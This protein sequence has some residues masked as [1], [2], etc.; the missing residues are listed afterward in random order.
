M[1][2]SSKHTEREYINTVCKNKIKAKNSLLKVEKHSEIE[3]NIIK[4]VRN[5]FG[6]KTEITKNKCQ[7]S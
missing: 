4:D 6:L 7:Y 2:H 1:N 3:D 5:L